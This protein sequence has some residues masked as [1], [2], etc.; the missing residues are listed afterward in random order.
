MPVGIGRRVA[1]HTIITFA[2]SDLPI[3][4][5]VEAQQS[6]GVPPMGGC[7][8]HQCTRALA[9]QK[10]R[11]PLTLFTRGTTVEEISFLPE[12]TPAAPEVSAIATAFEHRCRCR[13]A[14]RRRCPTGDLLSDM[15]SFIR[16]VCSG[17]APMWRVL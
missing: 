12:L 6:L 11:K 1:G 5:F 7:A 4:L 8:R 3:I 9:V 17:Y 13:S 15:P 2:I 14:K 10:A 16:R